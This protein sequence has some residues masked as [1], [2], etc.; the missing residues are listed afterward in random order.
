[1]RYVEFRDAIHAELRRSAAGLTWTELQSRLG[2]PYDRPCPTW[3]KQLEAD[4]RR[5]RTK[6]PGRSLVWRVG[7]GGRVTRSSSTS[8]EKL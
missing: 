7:S 6:G 3:T 8:V 5:Q 2:L 1:M 4:I